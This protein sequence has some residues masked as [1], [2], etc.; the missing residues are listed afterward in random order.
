MIGANSQ[1]SVALSSGID[2]DGRTEVELLED[3]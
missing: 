2:R 3:N 1:E